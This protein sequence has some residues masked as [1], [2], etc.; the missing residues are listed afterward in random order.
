[1]DL[2]FLNGL[3]KKYFIWI[4]KEENLKAMTV[5]VNRIHND[6]K[7]CNRLLNRIQV[8]LSRLTDQME[9]PFKNNS[10]ELRIKH[11]SLRDAI[12]FFIKS[13]K[14][15]RKQVLKVTMQVMDTEHVLLP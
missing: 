15:D 14:A 1:D 11:K 7:K 2:R 6:T 8:H 12:A 5:L 10:E 9:E 13:I 3:L 4:K